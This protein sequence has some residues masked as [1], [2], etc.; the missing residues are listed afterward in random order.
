MSAA[1][2]RSPRRRPPPRLVG[3]LAFALAVAP[4]A[5][6]TLHVDDD[7]NPCAPKN[8]TLACPYATIGD[9]VNAAVVGDVVLVLPGLYLEAVRM[10]NGVALVSRDGPEV[11]TIDATGRNSAA[12]YFRDND[13][14]TTLISTLSGFT[15]TGGSGEAR[16]AASRG[17]SEG[18]MS[19]G[20]VFIYN[21][22]KYLMS[23][24]IQNNV[25]TG[26]TL[27]SADSVRYP[28]LLGAGVYVAL[29]HSLITSN[30][31]TGNTADR[32]HANRRY[33]DGGGIYSGSYANPVVSG[34]TITGNVAG[35]GGGGIALYGGPSWYPTLPEI[36]ANLIEGNTSHEVAGAVSAGSYS[37]FVLTN[38]VIRNN[39]ADQ[40]GGAMFVYYGSV[41]VR[42]NTIVDNSATTTGGIWLDKADPGNF[43]SVENNIISDNSGTDPD[44]ASGIRSRLATPRI[45][46]FVYNDLVGNLPADFGGI[47]DPALSLG[48][49]EL[50][51]QFE[52]PLA[53][54]YRLLPGSP[55]IDAGS[56]ALAPP[57]DFDA[58]PRPLD[59]D[60]DATPA[61]DMGAFELHFD[62][63]GDEIPD[64]GS[65]NGVTGDAPCTGGE[66]T[67]CDDNCPDVANPL[68]EDLDGDGV[69][70]A[71]DP[72][73]DDDLVPN[74][75]DCAPTVNSVDQAPG[76]VS[77]LKTLD[78][79]G[80]FG[81][82]P[83]RQ[84]NVFNM[85][86]AQ[87]NAGEAFAY[88][89]SCVASEVPTTQWLD[90]GQPGARQVYYYLAAG[91][92][93]CGTG[94]LG[95]N[96]AGAPDPPATS[97]CFPQNLDTDTDLVPDL[98]DNCPLTANA[99]QADADRD[100]IGNVCDA[101]PS[102]AGND[103][104]GD[105][106][107][108]DVDNCPA[109]ANPAQADGDLDGAGDACDNCLAVP[110]STQSN[111][112]GDL[113]GDA[114]DPCP[115]DAL[116][117][118]DLDG[119][120]GNA[121]NCPAAANP[122]QDDGDADGV[123]TVCD[124]C[125]A[126]A[127]PSQADGDA[128]GTGNPCD[129]APGDPG[130]FAVPNEVQ[131]LLFDAD[132]ATLTWTSAVPASGPGTVHDLRRGLVDDLP[133]ETGPPDTCLAPG[134]PGTSTSD[135]T[136]P[137]PRAGFYYVIRGRNAC[138]SGSFGTASSGVERVHS[139]WTEVCTGGVDEDCN[140]SVDCADLACIA[141]P[142]CP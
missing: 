135:P 44:F 35:S 109:V 141:S 20:G 71:C 103:A 119:I 90:P 43:A 140:G 81:W 63:D 122:G 97:P 115:L 7:A 96:S 46:T 29:G 42:N 28:E 114:C 33:G 86:R 107:C 77:G 85:Y 138:G 101:C 50:P 78:L 74:A 1:R 19:G 112:D 68:Q 24:I 26:N 111:V 54:N 132:G 22:N 10:K 99:G 75:Q 93:A 3:A 108:G 48:N 127:N 45:L 121:D 15:V 14:A 120:C 58:V 18:A 134:S 129:C 53:G 84:S 110:N 124:N 94:I 34:N 9:A 137:A 79:A 123:G 61:A 92:N 31:I 38:N 21:R 116:N 5:A 87:R 2:P 17:A 82:Q 23:P 30:V 118:V 51:P 69:G 80:T 41:D 64:D 55:G 62:G 16:S 100:G 49:T 12:V 13:P 76:E 130:A 117:D 52:D 66:L 104:D 128:D 91:V 47:P 126:N 6:A 70:D 89:F 113:H 25:I 37:D 67:G 32:T 125:P 40:A 4:A 105:G 8:G 73:V 139:G 39:H 83:E 60:G 98:D 65:S 95:R 59:G 57:H 133:V 27:V 106:L 131:N 56:S 136:V 11:T 102:D 36:D 142:A 88:D 72:D